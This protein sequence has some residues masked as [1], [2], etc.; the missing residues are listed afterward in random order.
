MSRQTEHAAYVQ[1]AQELEVATTMVARLRETL[2]RARGRIEQ[3]EDILEKA[4]LPIP[5]ELARNR[6]PSGLFSV[7]AGLLAAI[8]EPRRRF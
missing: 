4:G 6:R 5:Q 8:P 3:L 1:K 7:I 2:E